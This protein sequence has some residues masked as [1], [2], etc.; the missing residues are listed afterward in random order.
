MHKVDVED[1]VG[2][3]RN[4]GMRRIRAGASSRSV[5]Q[6][7]WNKEPTLA[8]DVHPAEALIESWNHAAETLRNADGL[9]IAQLRLAVCSHL[10]L[11]IGAH[12]RCTMIIGRVKLFPIRRKPAGVMHLVDLVW[13]S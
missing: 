12:H 4:P 8:A 3:R 1:E 9:G 10:G 11:T 2:H 7:P 13:L 5:G 6:L